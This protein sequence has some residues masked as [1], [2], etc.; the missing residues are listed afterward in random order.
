[1]SYNGPNPVILRLK[2]RLMLW[3][4][5]LHHR[6]AKFLFSPDYFSCLGADLYFDKMIRLYLSKTVHLRNIYLPVSGIMQP[7]NIPGYRASRV[8]T[9]LP[10]HAPAVPLTPYAPGSVNP[11]IA[12]LLTSIMMDGSG[13]HGFFL[14]TVP[15][16]MGYL[17]TEEQLMLRHM[18]LCNHKIPVYAAK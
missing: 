12:P 5:D 11:A 9:D 4:M 10:P 16:L 17:S 7:E 14:Q 1:M 15:I 8:H 13:G 6:V 3:S 18:P 2:M